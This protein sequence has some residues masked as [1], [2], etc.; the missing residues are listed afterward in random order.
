[1]TSQHI[2][3]D[4]A[5]RVHVQLSARDANR[6]FSRGD[7]LISLPVAGLVRDIDGPPVER[8]SIFLTELAGLSGGLTRLFVDEPSAAAFT[9]A[10]SDQLQRIQ[11]DLEV[12]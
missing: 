10:V 8:T 5:V 7:P 4:V 2:G 9:T 3:D 12:V 1:M 6:V 11:Q